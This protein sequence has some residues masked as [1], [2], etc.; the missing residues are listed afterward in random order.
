MPFRHAQ[1]SSTQPF[2]TS[3]LP[4]PSPSLCNAFRHC[5]EGRNPGRSIAG[6]QDSYTIAASN[7][8]HSGNLLPAGLSWIAASAVM[9]V[10]PLVTPSPSG[11]LRTVMPAIR[12]SRESGTYPVLQQALDFRLR[13]RDGN[14][15]A[16]AFR[17][18]GEGRN[19]GRSIDGFQDGYCEGEGLFLDTGYP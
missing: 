10:Q 15:G 9:T 14:W 6:F 5:G 3:S 8:H 17:H 16:I 7:T 1:P 13:R 19:P 18:Y 11:A 4:Q 12:R 2:V